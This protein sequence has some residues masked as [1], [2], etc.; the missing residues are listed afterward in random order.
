MSENDM[1]ALFENLIKVRLEGETDPAKIAKIQATKEKMRA[2]R[3]EMQDAMARAKE[4]IQEE[5]KRM[6]EI[7][8]RNRAIVKEKSKEDIQNRNETLMRV[9]LHTNLINAIADQYQKP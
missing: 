1:D 9:E 5:K 7:S 2:L 6:D 8:E 4:E 3:Q